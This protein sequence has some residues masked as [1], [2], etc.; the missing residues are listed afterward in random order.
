VLDRKTGTLEHR[1]FYELPNFLSPKDAL[2]VN[3]TKVLPA[4]FRGV[5]P[6]TQGRVEFV[7]LEDLGNH[8]WEGLL[9]ITAKQRVG[10]KVQFQ[11]PNGD[12]LNAVI[13]RTAAQSEGGT[14]RLLFDQDP[15]LSGAGEMPLPSYIDQADLA[16][17]TKSYQTQ[18]AKVPGAAAAP[19]AGLHFTPGLMDTLRNRGVGWYETTLHVGVGTFRPVKCQNISEHKMHEEAFDISNEVANGLSFHRKNNGRVVAVGTTVVRT[20]ESSAFTKNKTDYELRA[21]PGRTRIFLYPGAAE[22]H[23]VDRLITNFHLP[24]STLL[25]LVCAFAGKDLVFKAYQEAIEKKYR[26]FSYGDAMLIL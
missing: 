1:F 3:N 5:R 14:T 9:Q 7:L 2:V 23:F 13:E 24:K 17:V 19:T 20:L 16:K 8:L 25:M 10:L 6:D 26:F 12:L 4:R 21:G 11:K 18:F 22:F 15:V